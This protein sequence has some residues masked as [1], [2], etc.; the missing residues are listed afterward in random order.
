MI[1]Q[2]PSYIT[3]T[4]LFT[5]ILTS[6]IFVKAIRQSNA[7][8]KGLYIMIGISIWM[9]LQGVLSYNGYYLDTVAD[10]PPPFPFIGFIP[11]FIL[12]AILF[13]TNKGRSFIDSLPAYELTLLSIVRIPVEIVLHWIFIAKLIPEAMTF[14]GYNFDIIAGITAPLIAYFGYKKASLGKSTLL[15]WN[16]IS[17]LLLI[18]IILLSVFAFPSAIQKYAWDQANVGMLY[19]PFFWLPSF[20]VPVV[21]FSHLVL[22]RRLVK[23]EL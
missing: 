3:I 5:V 2:I 19:F 12:M 10:F 20:I 13:N 4:F 23:T 14:N 7:K 21:F 11:T 8:S 15:A 17:L 9:I 1:P 18:T 16:I 22:I 6:G